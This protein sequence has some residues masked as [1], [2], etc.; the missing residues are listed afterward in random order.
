[1]FLRFSL[2]SPDRDSG[3]RR[4]I[5][6]AAHELRD[7]E[8]LS[9]AEHEELRVSLAWFNMNL[10][11]PACLA[12]P[13]NRRALSWFKPG[14]TKPIARMW[15]LKAIL[16]NHGYTVDVLKTDDPGIVLFEDGWQVVAKPPKGKKVS[17]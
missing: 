13:N 2:K 1:M 11:H 15:A 5:L 16:E 12:D 6:V 8:G 14:A 3:Y 10:N 9:V 4:G 7:S 17:W